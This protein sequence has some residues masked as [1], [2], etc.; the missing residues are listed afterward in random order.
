M[1]RKADFNAEE[2]SLVV[3]APALAGLRV[4]SA[5]RGGTLRETVSMGRAYAEARQHENTT[6]LLREIV[7]SAPQVDPRGFGSPDELAAES[8][9]RLREAVRVLTEKATPEEVDDYQRFVRWLAEQVA[10]AHKEG[11][12][13]GLGG[14]PVSERELAA[15]DEIAAALGLPPSADSS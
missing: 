5:E 7:S 15:L 13:L 10:A 1:T 14:K 4:I 8:V 9:R 12:V 2:W 6:D 11:G 3:E